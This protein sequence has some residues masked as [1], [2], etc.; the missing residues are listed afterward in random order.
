MHSSCGT[1]STA[2]SS[3]VA[4]MKNDALQAY[5]DLIKLF[6]NNSIDVNAFEARF[7]GRF[8]SESAALPDDKFQI[9]DELFAATDAFCPD[10]ELRDANDLS[11][12]QL[13]TKAAEA[14]ARLAGK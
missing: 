14:L 7:L 2:A 10:P 4:D 13:R 8:K 5:I 6:L 11:E 1:S 9:L 12:E 3:E